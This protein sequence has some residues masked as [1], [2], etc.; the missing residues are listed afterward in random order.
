MRLL[1]RTQAFADASLSRRPWAPAGIAQIAQFARRST[2]LTPLAG[3]S[4]VSLL[5]SLGI[6]VLYARLGGARAFGT[7]QITLAITGALGVVALSGTGTAATRAAAQGRSAAWPLFRLRLPYVAA[8]AAILL[9]AGAALASAGNGSLGAALLAAGVATPFFLGADVYPSHLIG[10]GRYRSYF[11]FQL[12]VQALT[13]VAVAGTLALA[14]HEP[15]TAV[16]AM[17]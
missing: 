6:T 1:E 15:W 3:V 12:A 10:T 8:A 14:P 11:A 9:V 5:N 7:Y 4:A 13:L 16:L 2:R 17:T